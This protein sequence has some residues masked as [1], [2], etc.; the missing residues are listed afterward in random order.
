MSIYV[1]LWHLKFPR[2][3]DDHTDCEW[4]D[5]IA[6]GVPAHVGSP[7]PRCGYGTGD[8]YADFLPPAVEL[9]PE[10]DGTVLRAVV[11]VTAETA[12]GTARSG[13]E[14]V[15]PLLVLSGKAYAALSFEQLHEQLCAA[16]RRDRPRV[17]MEV[18]GGD[19]GIRLVFEDG[20][21]KDLRREVDS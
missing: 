13:Q 9:P 7:T 16:L 1:T 15:D 4:I 11:F 2:H 17:V 10:D 18:L 19:G 8:P 20:A 21:V 14:Y 3:G 12:K 5:V 6:Q